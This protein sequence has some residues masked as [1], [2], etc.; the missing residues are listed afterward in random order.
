MGFLSGLIIGSVFGSFVSIFVIA[1]VS[2]NSHTDYEDYEQ[3]KHYESID[4]KEVE[5]RNE[6]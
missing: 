1:L 5:D 3:E 4:K 6:F 2:A